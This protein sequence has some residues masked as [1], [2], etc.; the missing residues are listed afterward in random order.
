MPS[1]YSF[2]D[3]RLGKL[4]GF[5]VEFDEVHERADLQAIQAR[6]AGFRE[7]DEASLAASRQSLPTPETQAH[8][9]SEKTHYNHALQQLLAAKQSDI[10]ALEYLPPEL[11]AS[12]VARLLVSGYQAGVQAAQNQPKVDTSSQNNQGEQL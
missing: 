10:L 8:A 4:D 1:P 6:R 3:P 7:P 11:L 12:H 2:F 9:D 5:Q